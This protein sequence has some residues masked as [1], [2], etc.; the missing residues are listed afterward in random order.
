MGWLVLFVKTLLLN[1]VLLYTSFLFFKTCYS[2]TIIDTLPISFVSD[3]SQYLS[4][5]VLY[6]KKYLHS[7]FMV[8]FRFSR[9]I[10]TSVSFIRKYIYSSVVF[11]T[12]N[13]SPLLKLFTSIAAF[14]FIDAPICVRA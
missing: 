5:L 11:V 14:S 13:R 4:N 9:H 10:L 2:Y 3:T 1:K 7:Y 8:N 6:R 12:L